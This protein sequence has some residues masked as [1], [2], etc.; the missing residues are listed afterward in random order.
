MNPLAPVTSAVPLT[1]PGY[2]DLH[3]VRT[4]GCAT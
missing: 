4:P 1:D 2:S 3:S